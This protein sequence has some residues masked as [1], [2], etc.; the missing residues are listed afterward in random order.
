MCCIPS[1]SSQD[2]N[3]YWE[4]IWNS[5]AWNLSAGRVPGDSE[6]CNAIKWVASSP[7]V[8]WEHVVL[9]VVATLLWNTTLSPKHLWGT[10]GQ[11]CT[12][13][14]HQ[15]YNLL[16]SSQAGEGMNL[17]EGAANPSF[18][19]GTRKLSA[20]L[21]PPWCAWNHL[22]YLKTAM[23]HLWEIPV[24]FPRSCLGARINFFKHIHTQTN[25]TPH[26]YTI[27]IHTPCTHIIHTYLTNVPHLYT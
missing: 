10:I 22:R 18:W 7:R 1:P 15:Q 27:Y 6:P 8:L 12:K 17:R 26:R 24:Y 14:R 9:K 19:L 5:P 21:I 16:C 11:K 2:K 23:P 4:R 13:P 3:V 20:S 25:H